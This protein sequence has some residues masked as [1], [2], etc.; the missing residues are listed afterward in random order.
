M[1]SQKP[2]LRNKVHPTA[3]NIFHMNTT[4]HF[5]ATIYSSPNQVEYMDSLKPGSIPS[6]EIM[7]QIKEAYIISPGEL[8]VKSHFVQRQSNVDCGAFSVAN[9]WNVLRNGDPRCTFFFQSSLR[10]ELYRSFQNGVLTFRK[11]CCRAR[12]KPSSYYFNL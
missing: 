8:V 9:L 1:F 2:S 4:N 12:R 5:V 3:A 11:R 7:K 10:S 6:E